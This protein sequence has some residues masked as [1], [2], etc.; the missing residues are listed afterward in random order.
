MSSS[1]I[2]ITKAE[3]PGFLIKGLSIVLLLYVAGHYFAKNY[4]IGI[5]KQ[6]DPCIPGNRV[7]LVEKKSALDIERD[8]IY[9]FISKDLSPF[10]HQ[11]TKM[12]KYARALPGDQVRI[13]EHDDVYINNRYIA[14]GLPVADTMKIDKQKFRGSQIVKDNEYWFMGTSPRSFD[15]RYWGS[16]KRNEIVSRAY[17]LF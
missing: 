1:L 11:G 14:S 6:K 9:L 7:Y 12:L 2:K 10:Y 8:K 3:L 5:D 16:V 15:S 13:T 4:S 17:P